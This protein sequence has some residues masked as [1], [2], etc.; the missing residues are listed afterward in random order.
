MARQ[1]WA[2]IFFFF[3]KWCISTRWHWK[4]SNDTTCG[5]PGLK[6]EHRDAAETGFSSVPLDTS[7]ERLWHL[8]KHYKL[9][10]NIYKKKKMTDICVFFVGFNGS[11]HL[12]H[13]PGQNE[14]KKKN[15]HK[16]KKQNK[17]STRHTAKTFWLTKCM[18]VQTYIHF[19]NNLQTSVYTSAPLFT[20]VVEYISVS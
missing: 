9:F 1:L 3:F 10:C 12:A 19:S 16:R 4:W 5:P 18:T 7:S 13:S 15:D 8:A 2:Y 6:S 14:K 11:G 17:T 20:I